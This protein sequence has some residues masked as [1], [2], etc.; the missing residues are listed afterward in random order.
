M[1]RYGKVRAVGLRFDWSVE[2]QVGLVLVPAVQSTGAIEP[3]IGGHYFGVCV[4]TYG[5]NRFLNTCL[6]LTVSN[7]SRRK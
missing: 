2:N 7:N 3:E 5:G 6:E 1:N 4:A